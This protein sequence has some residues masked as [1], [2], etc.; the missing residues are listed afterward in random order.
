MTFHTPRK[1]YALLTV[2]HPL[3]SQNL[4]GIAKRYID[5]MIGKCDANVAE[6]S[7][8]KLSRIHFFAV[9]NRDIKPSCPNSHVNSEI[10][11]RQSTFDS[12]F[13]AFQK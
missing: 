5:Y 7:V 9:I 13:L 2:L 8:Q 1:L 11:D 6:H 12:S 3:P 10:K 4:Q